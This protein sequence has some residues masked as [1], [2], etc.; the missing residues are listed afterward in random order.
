[1]V[2]FGCMEKVAQMP[3]VLIPIHFDRDVVGRQ[4]SCQHSVVLR[5][6][7]THDFMTGVPAYPGVHLPLKV[8][9]FSCKFSHYC[10]LTCD[11]LNAVCICF[12]KFLPVYIII[13]IFFLL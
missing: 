2:E 5:P 10:F 3:V 4:P 11:L 12:L 6:F 1:M 8:S 7:V 9:S 13:N